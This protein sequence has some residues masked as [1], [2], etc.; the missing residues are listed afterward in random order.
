MVNSVAVVALGCDGSSQA[1]CE[2]LPLNIDAGLFFMLTCYRE[3]VTI[4][5]NTGSDLSDG[6]G[7][8]RRS[9]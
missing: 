1:G 5:A 9:C 6:M 3:L 7:P 2:G 4:D 8:R